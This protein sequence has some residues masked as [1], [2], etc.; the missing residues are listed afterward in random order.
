MAGSCALITSTRPFAWKACVVPGGPR[1]T[2]LR[3]GPTT[4]HLRAH[5]A[6]PTPP[7]SAPSRSGARAAG[8]PPPRRSPAGPKNRSV[9]VFRRLQNLPSAREPL[10]VEDA[11]ASVWLGVHG[12]SPHRRESGVDVDLNVASDTII[13][14]VSGTCSHVARGPHPIVAAIKRRRPDRHDAAEARRC[15][16]LRSTRFASLPPRL[17][18]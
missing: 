1:A 7:R 11:V 16:D 8:A 13:D 3:R 15:A 5:A 4:G 2:G 9:A 14:V 6:F 17:L 18:A 12:P 10:D